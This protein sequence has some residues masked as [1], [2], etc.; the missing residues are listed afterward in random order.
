[1]SDPTVPKEAS[2]WLS[3]EANVVNAMRWIERRANVAANLDPITFNDVLLGGLIREGVPA[4]I[5]IRILRAPAVQSQL[6][7]WMAKSAPLRQP[8][9][10]GAIAT[11][12][13]LSP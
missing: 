7:I 8:L 3:R 4:A 5:G 11:K 13:L 1:M 9:Q 10:S 2:T 6:G 12:N